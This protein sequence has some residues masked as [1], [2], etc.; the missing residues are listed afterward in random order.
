MGQ[1][2]KHA[3]QIRKLRRIFRCEPKFQISKTV[4]ISVD[5]ADRFARLLVRRDENN[6]D[7]RMEKQ[8]AQQLR[9]AVT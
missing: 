4:Q 6:F 5:F 1:R 3:I 9:A 8:Y 7:V 2:Q